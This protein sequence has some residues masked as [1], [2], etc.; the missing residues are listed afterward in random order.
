MSKTAM[1]MV[2]EAR[3]QVVEVTRAGGGRLARCHVVN[4]R[5]PEMATRPWTASACAR[6]LLSLVDPAAPPPGPARPRP[7]MVIICASG[8]RASLAALTSRPWATA[9]AILDGGLKGWRGRA[10]HRRAPFSASDHPPVECVSDL[11][12]GG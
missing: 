4:V 8:A 11:E 5:G 3:A 1:Q 12:R 9:A 10:T 2:G 7:R 6:G